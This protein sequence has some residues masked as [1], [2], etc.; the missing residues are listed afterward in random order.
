MLGAGILSA[1]RGSVGGLG[2]VLLVL[3]GAGLAIMGRLWHRG[4]LQSA[5]RMGRP[6]SIRGYRLDLLGDSRFTS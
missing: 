1:T 5:R 6:M 4:L 3:T 2:A